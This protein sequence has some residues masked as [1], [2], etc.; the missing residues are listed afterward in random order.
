MP[1][2]DNIDVVAEAIRNAYDQH[3]QTKHNQPPL[4]PWSTLPEERKIKWRNMAQA[5]REVICS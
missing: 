1:K 2:Q 5:A 4:R 3:A